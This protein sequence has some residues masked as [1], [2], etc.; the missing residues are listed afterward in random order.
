MALDLVTNPLMEIGPIGLM[1]PRLEDYTFH[2][3]GQHV[4]AL[5]TCLFAPVSLQKDLV[6]KDLVQR[7][8]R[9]E[10]LCHG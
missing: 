10:D 9:R 4:L 7:C 1:L 8:S 2:D 3:R 6:Q 5:C